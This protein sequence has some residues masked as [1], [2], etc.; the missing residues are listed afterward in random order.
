MG[1]V[2]R[3]GVIVENIQELLKGIKITLELTLVAILLSTLL[4]IIIAFIFINSNRVVKAII[5]VYVEIMR[6]VPLL[7]LLYFIYF[8]LGEISIDFGSFSSIILALVLCNGA[9]LEEIIRAGIESVHKTQSEAG[10]ALG[11]HNYQVFFRIVMPQALINVFPP[12]IN[13]YVIIMLSTSFASLVALDELTSTVS[14]ISAFS[15]RTF[16]FYIVGAVVYLVFAIF[17]AFVAN[18]IKKILKHEKITKQKR[19]T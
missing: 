17:I 1:Y 18:R 4:G 6:N 19:T 12:I 2:I 15:F 13:Q 3:F 9:Y 10:M 16:E 8:G 14:R 11:L 5:N 7:V